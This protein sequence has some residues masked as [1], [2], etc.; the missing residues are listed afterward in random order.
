[1]RRAALALALTAS[2][3]GATPALAAAPSRSLAQRYAHRTYITDPTLGRRVYHLDT[4]RLSFRAA[5]GSTISAWG[6]VLNSGDGTGEI[7]LLFR[8]LKF[9]GWASAYDAVHL[10]VKTSGAAIA[11]TYGVYSGNDPFCCPHAR[12]TIRYRWNGRRIVASGEPP[13][14]YGRRGNRLHLAPARD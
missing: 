14:A 7:V 12:K 13:L 3:A 9:L 10:S 8:N 2:V 4:P 11:V 5:D 6:A 1:M